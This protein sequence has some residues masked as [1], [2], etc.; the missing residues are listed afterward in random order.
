M[1]NRGNI[2]GIGEIGIGA[3]V[4]V[5][6]FLMTHNM[7]DNEDQIVNDRLLASEIT[8]NGEIIYTAEDDDFWHC[9]IDQLEGMQ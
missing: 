1:R 2:E 7:Q 8:Q 4:T 5:T 3:Q 6:G 9:I